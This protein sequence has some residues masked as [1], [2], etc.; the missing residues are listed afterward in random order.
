ME[1]FPNVSSAQVE[2]DKLQISDKEFQQLSKLIYKEAGIN[3]SDNKKSLVISRLRTRLSTLGLGSFSE[4]YDKVLNDE[5]GTELSVLLDAISTNVTSFFR[6][7]NHFEFL[8]DTVIPELTEQYNTSRE[9]SYIHWWSS[10]SSTGQEPYSM[11]I[12][13]LESVDRPARYNFKLLATDISNPA[14]EEAREAVYQEK[15]LSKIN[16]ATKN[17]YFTKAR[18]YG[19]GYYKV[20]QPVRDLVTFGRLNLNQNRFPFDRKFDLIFCRNVTIYFDQPIVQ[21]LINKFERNLKSG[22][23]LFMGHSESL[24]GI[25]SGLS[26]I[27]PTIYQ[28]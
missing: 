23:Y 14:L 25:D 10:A 9:R 7:Y 6:E 2:N 21:K 20:C 8:Q 17:Q 3:L 19:S 4:Y 12:S 28:K 24:A 13:W 5:T 15:E 26:F 18:D 27:E 16:P 1:R 11:A 22:G